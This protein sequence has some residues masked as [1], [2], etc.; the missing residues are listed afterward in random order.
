MSLSRPYESPTLTN[1]IDRKLG[2]FDRKLEGSHS[3]SPGYFDTFLRIRNKNGK[4][5]SF[6]FNQTRCKNHKQLPWHHR[7]R[8]HTPII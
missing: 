8:S 6:S 3:I 1:Q 4:I 2:V 5:K 7:P